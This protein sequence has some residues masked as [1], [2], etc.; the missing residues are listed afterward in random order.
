MNLPQR[1]I[2]TV[3][4]FAVLLTLSPSCLLPA[5]PPTACA[6]D[7]P[8]IMGPERSGQATGQAELSASWPKAP[9]IAWQADIGSGY[10]GPAVVGEQVLA[11]HRLGQDELLESFD[12]STGKSQWRA[13]WPA[14]Y[15]SSIDPDNGPRC[16]PTVAPASTTSNCPTVIC[17]G[18]AGDL[19]AVDLDS[20]KL[21]WHRKLRSEYRADDGYFG[22]G[23]APLVVGHRVIVCLGGKQAGIVAVDLES[24]ET[25]WTATD[26]DA[27]YS[28]PVAVD[29]Q[30]ALVVTRLNTLL[31]D[32][33]TGDVLS[34]IRFGSRG[35][36]VNAA[37]P[38]PIGSG[39]F[40][41]TASYGV[42]MTIVS[43]NHRKLE[44]IISGSQ[45]LSSQY[46][47]PV[48][49]ANRIVGIDGRED[50]GLAALRCIDLDSQKVLW[51]KTD[52]GTAHLIAIGSQVLTLTI[53]GRVALIDAAADGY[54]ELAHTQLPA[55]TYRAPPALSSGKFIVR[56]NHNAN[57]SKL[58]CVEL[59]R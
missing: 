50:V 4:L 56:D 13:T 49:A 31:V 46:N 27:S 17:Y 10:A 40:L 35:P 58:L 25:L 28:A 33:D 32:L 30:T 18:A 53:P 34:E 37:V 43:T 12:L 52:Y 8:Q 26:Y 20:G 11:L 22:A 54:H 5:V 51:T 55:G 48:L 19:A 2:F 9:N 6:Q 21:R 1:T 44:A 57:K 36:T 38:I 23:S 24:G 45:L 15:R 39:R 42:G 7:W 3:S 14:S 29:P 59:L 41:L 16:V 47:T